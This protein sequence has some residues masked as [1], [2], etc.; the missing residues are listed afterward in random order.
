MNIHDDY[1]DF[2]WLALDVLVEIVIFD[3]MVFPAMTLPCRQMHVP[4]R[5]G[6]F[7]PFQ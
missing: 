5:I 3:W 2:V 6:D 7:E 4:S 1:N